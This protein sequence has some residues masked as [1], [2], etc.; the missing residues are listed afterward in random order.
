MWELPA[1]AKPILQLSIGLTWGLLGTVSVG[2]GLAVPVE[3]SPELFATEFV[4]AG[5]EQGLK[6][7]RLKSALGLTLGERLLEVSLDYQLSGAAVQ[8]HDTGVLSQQVKTRLNSELLDSVLGID[9]DLDTHSSFREGGAVYQHRVRPGLSRSFS[10]LAILSVNYEYELARASPLSLEQERRGYAMM[11]DGA[12]H[13]G[14][15]TWRG[16]YRRG[17]SAT[18]YGAALGWSPSARYILALKVDSLQQL[19]EQRQEI[20]GSGSISW[21]PRPDLELKLDYGDQLLQG[22]SGWMLH[23]LSLIHI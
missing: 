23:T 4:A 10:D 13:D 2:Q 3:I 7:A 14:R 19:Q 15:L 17:D 1:V 11:L 6:E 8:D 16:S 21:F 18:R 12:L 5:P 20:L 9:L 22:A